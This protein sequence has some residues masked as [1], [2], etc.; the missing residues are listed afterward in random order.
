MTY[1]FGHTAG[2]RGQ[3]KPSKLKRVAKLSK[4]EVTGCA[5]GAHATAVVTRDGKLYMFGSLEEDLVD[6][7]S[8]RRGLTVIHCA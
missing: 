8:G 6:K 7:S 3:P 5:C 4:H 1:I 2:G